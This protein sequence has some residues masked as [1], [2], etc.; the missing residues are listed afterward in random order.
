MRKSGP[1]GSETHSVELYRSLDGATADRLTLLLASMGIACQVR[2]GQGQSSAI[3]VAEADLGRARELINDEY[4][5]GIGTGRD[6]PPATGVGSGPT[7]VAEAQGWMGPGTPMVV[8]LVLLCVVLYSALHLGAESLSRSRLL[9]FG[10]ISWSHVEAGQHWRLIAAI[11]VHFNISHLVSNMV[12][13]VMLAPPLANM[14]GAR[15]FLV[16]FLVAGL[17]G[18]VLS[19]LLSPAMGLK[20]GA[21]GAIAGVLGG[22]GGQALRTGGRPSRFRS[23]HVLGGMLAFYAMMIG[24]G[25]GRDNLAHL[26]GM[27]A[28]IILGRLIDPAAPATTFSQEPQYRPGSD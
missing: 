8:F 23:W 24:F 6:Q 26:G 22:L 27:L 20:A 14:L 2:S 5:Y 11:F 19:H 28:G 21:S 12:T 16:L 1:H 18:N 13:M 17:A 7:A 3:Y 15:R 10:A 9:E 4:P 25:P